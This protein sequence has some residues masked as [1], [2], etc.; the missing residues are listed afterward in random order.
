MEAALYDPV[1]GYYHRSD[2]KRW[3]REA[4]YRTSAERSELFAATFARYFARRYEELGCPSRWTIVEGGAGE[5][6]FAQRVLEVLADEYP[7]VFGATRY[8]LDE[9]SADSL[10]RARER[11]RPFQ[12]RVSYE[13]RESVEVGIYFSNELLDAFPVHRVVRDGELYVTLDSED[14]FVWSVGPFST[15][16]LA[17]YALLLE[18]SQVTEI[19]LEMEDWFASVAAKIAHG[20]V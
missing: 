8:C 20:Y 19:N 2:L 9:I 6:Y 7:R 5:A 1:E 18:P 14:K 13:W 11:L 17:E 4:D 15:P 12:E 3:G 10:S 16:R